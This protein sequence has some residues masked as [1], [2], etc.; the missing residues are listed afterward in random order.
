MKQT[1]KSYENIS[2]IKFWFCVIPWLAINCTGIS[3]SVQYFASLVCDILTI[4][5]T[6]LESSF[7]TFVG[8]Q[9]YYYLI[10]IWSLLLT[11]YKVA[12]HFVFYYLSI[13][14]NHHAHYIQGYVEAQSNI[15]QK[16]VTVTWSGG[17]P[18]C[19]TCGTGS[20]TQ[21]YACSANAW[22]DWNQGAFVKETIKT[23]E[24]NLYNEVP[25][26]FVKKWVS[27]VVI[28]SSSSTTSI[29][30]PL[31][32]LFHVGDW[33]EGKLIF[34]DPYPM[35]G[36]TY[37][38]TQVSV[39][40]FG[41]FDCQQTDPGD[42]RFQISVSNTSIGT[43]MEF[44]VLKCFKIEIYLLISFSNQKYAL[45]P[46]VWIRSKFSPMNISRDF[47]TTIWEETIRYTS[48]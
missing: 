22:P 25:W 46:T 8:W 30:A 37:T 47:P 16:S 12:D 35:D 14:H 10:R 39:E 9:H 26:K 3:F 13:N 29:S 34:V 40:L 11:K 1:M 31:S 32:I 28:A 18:I 17:S 24:T 2:F 21:S 7:P 20:V 5:A 38:I 15:V 48:T 27:L 6:Q 41:L 19:L 45:V 43:P 33:Q 4:V 44:Q 42:I 23:R 36:Y